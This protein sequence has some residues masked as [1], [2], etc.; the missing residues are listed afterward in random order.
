MPLAS[1]NRIGSYEIVG[2]LGEGGM[3]V[4]YRAR[5][6]RL[7]RDVA[8][9]LLPDH[10]AGDPDRLARL[11]REA[12]LLASLNHPHIAQIHGLEL[13]GAVTCIVMELVDGP[14]LADLIAGRTGGLPVDQ[15]CDIALQIATALEA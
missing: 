1:G 15:T 14:A 8:L 5:D 2:P 10:L 7:Q 11:E 9:K 12:Q 6:T 13:E 3:G 4:V